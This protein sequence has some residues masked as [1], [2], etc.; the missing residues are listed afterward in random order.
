M[1]AKHRKIKKWEPTTLEFPTTGRPGRPSRALSQRRARVENLLIDTVLKIRKQISFTPG[2]R[3]WCYLLEDHG[4]QK[5][6]FATAQNLINTA[7]KD[8]RL[9]IDICAE[10]DSRAFHNLEI[11]DDPDIE[12]EATHWISWLI[13]N[14]WIDYNPISFWTTQEYYIQIIVEKVDLLQ[15]FRSVCAKY[16]VPIANMKGWPDIGSRFAMLQRFKYWHEQGKKCVLLMAGDHDPAG[17]AIT[18]FY[19][20]MLQELSNAVKWSPNQ[21][22]L[23]IERFGLNYDLIIEAGLSWIDN[24]E[25]SSGGDLSSP[26]HADHYKPYV[27]EYLKRYGARKVEANALVTRPDLAKKLI[28]STLN[29]YIDEEQ[30]VEFEFELKRKRKELSAEVKRQLQLFREF[31]S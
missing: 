22:N 3:G 5:G 8:G 10:D 19:R 9:P 31:N 4:L 2:S 25:T 29:K 11:L 21:E 1:P 23:I 16:N 7:R 20:N 26:K 13:N 18:D 6:D 30:M 27:Q 28:Q 14:E 24:L 17:L 15:L 12:D